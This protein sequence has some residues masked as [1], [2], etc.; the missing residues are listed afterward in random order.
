MKIKRVS[1]IIKNDSVQSYSDHSQFNESM[2]SV[3]RGR[4]VWNGG[5]SSESTSTV[6]L[7]GVRVSDAANPLYGFTLT[8]LDG[9]FD[10]LVNGGRTRI[11][12]SVYVPPNEIVIVDPIRMARDEMR[13]LNARPECAVA[14]RALPTPVLRPEWTVSTEG[15]PSARDSAA[16]LVVDTRSVLQSLPLPG[17]SVRLVY[18]SSRVSASESILVMGLLPE[19]IDP[20]LRLVHVLVDI[21]GRKFEK[22]LAPSENLTYVWSWDKLNVYRQSDHGM[23]PANVRIGYEYRGCGR[24]SEIAWVKRRVFMEGARARRLEGG[25]W[26]VDIHHHLDAVNG[27]FLVEAPPPA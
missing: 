21:A 16:T 3:I 25:A 19:K 22:R 23:V 17:S 11:K 26:S 20:D 5:A 12:R 13:E 15:I 6:A 7:P 14:N 9:E 27:Q 8:R 1:F 18:D 2:V 10:L 24:A 4:V